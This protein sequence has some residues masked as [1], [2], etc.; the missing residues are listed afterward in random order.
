MIWFKSSRSETKNYL[1]RFV[2]D[3][4]SRKWLVYAFMGLF[5][6]GMVFLY[7]SNSTETEEN[8]PA[9]PPQSTFV[10]DFSFFTSQDTSGLISPK[11]PTSAGVLTYQNWGWAATNVLVW[12]TILTIGLVVPV[13]AFVKSFE[14]QP[15]R[16]GDGRW[17]WSYSFTVFGI[18]HTAKLYG[19][20]S[21]DGTEWEMYITK[22]GVYI[23]FLWYT[24]QADLL[25]TTGTWTVYAE[26]NNPTPLLLIE[27]NRDT[28]NDT[29][30]IKYTNIVPGGNENGGY[31]HYGVTT[32]T[33][34]NAFYDI[35]NK[36]LNNQTDIEWHLTTH[37][38]R[39][40]DENR[41]Q[42]I[43]WHCWSSS[44]EDVV[45]Q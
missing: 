3:L 39:V 7:C 8:A 22:Q 40:K 36:G 16:Q 15:E 2:M 28:Q 19:S 24:G 37:E 13:A 12:N 25:A 30:D 21:N 41:F 27:W 42:D 32:E 26:P 9:I 17:R 43:E 34:Y 33:P 38:G 11:V 23:D 35:Y 20:I 10:M 4:I 5:L 14:S 29:G 18:T 6:S 31:I 45:C 44:L 1:W